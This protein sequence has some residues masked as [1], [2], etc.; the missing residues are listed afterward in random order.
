MDTILR[1]GD[2]QKKNPV[3][4]SYLQS[5][6][7]GPESTIAKGEW[8]L[9][10][11][12]LELLK[13]DPEL[14]FQVT[15][16]LLKRARTKDKDGKIPE[17]RFSDFV[18]WKSYI[19]AALTNKSKYKNEVEAEVKAHLDPKSGIDKSWS[20]NAS[21]ASLMF[22]FA[23]L[24]SFSNIDSP[25]KTDLIMQYLRRYGDANMAYTDLKAFVEALDSQDLTRLLPILIENR[26]FGGSDSDAMKKHLYPLN[27]EVS[28]K[29]S[30]CSILSNNLSRRVS[31][32][33]KQEDRR[34][35]NRREG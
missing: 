21:L 27:Q 13:N 3:R 30:N 23:P 20:R 9:W 1:S 26:I 6:F 33:S 10:I 5:P 35:Y 29:D 25:S 14:L 11:L 34:L 18:V 16:D 17:S 7:V 4:L 8:R 28:F 31:M 32:A 12:K 2:T 24:S 15:K 22:S 19:D